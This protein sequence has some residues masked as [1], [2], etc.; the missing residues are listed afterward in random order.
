MILHKNS[1]HYKLYEFTFS[2]H[3]EVPTTT[4]LCSYCQRIFWH[5]LLWF[6]L[7]STIIFI[8]GYGYLYSALY[9]HTIKT[10]IY[11]LVVIGIFFSIVLL[12]CWRE[13]FHKKYNDRP[14]SLFKQWLT[15]KKQRIC[16]LIEFANKEDPSNEANQ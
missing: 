4:N 11:T 15:A 3:I 2:S 13:I 8:V 10:I 12:A 14:P 9:L 1:W 6:F 7:A 16:P 5:G